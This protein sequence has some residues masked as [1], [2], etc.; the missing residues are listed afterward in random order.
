V[1]ADRPISTLLPVPPP[2]VKAKPGRGKTA[3]PR[4]VSAPPASRLADYMARA[5]LH[6]KLASRVLI[7]Q[8]RFLQGEEAYTPYGAAVLRQPLDRSIPAKQKLLD[9]TLARYRQC[10][11]LG[12]SEWAHA[13]TYRI[14][15]ALVAFGDALQQSE[16]PADLKGEDIAAYNE[17]LSNQ[18]RVFY[19]RGE[20]V[21]AELL[22]QKQRETPDEPWIRQA[23]SSLW[24]RLG[25][26]FRYRTEADV[27][28]VTGEEPAAD[29]AAE[30]RSRP[31]T[32]RA[33]RG[34]R[35]SDVRAQ[36]EGVE[37]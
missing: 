1:N 12:D 25:G 10:V 36:Q 4:R 29:Q 11:D 6:P 23:Q 17:I 14:G 21:W 27:P 2:P 35:G 13:S 15:Q 18:A 24:K 22:R 32:A 37:R 7:A 16:R 34:Q 31:D 30:S 19:T 26:R 20:D 28:L 3:P 9:Q 33:R 5:E 8:V